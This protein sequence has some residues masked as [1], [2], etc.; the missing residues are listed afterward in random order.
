MLHADLIAP[1]PT[2]LDR[3][4]KERPEQVA[5]WDGSRSITYARLASTTA[6]IAA[7]LTKA[8]VREGDKVA[9]YL[10]NGVDWVERGPICELSDK[11]VL[12]SPLPLFHSSFPSVTTRRKVRSAIAWPTQAVSPLSRRR[13]G[14]I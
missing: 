5:Y 13:P 12:L 7:N 4:S 14:K 2:L 3:H 10:P 11:D 8:G 9:I 6:S 1:I